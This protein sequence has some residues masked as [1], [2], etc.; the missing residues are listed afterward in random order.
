[1]SD[2][3]LEQVVQLALKLTISEQAKLLERV[4]ANLAREVQPP[5]HLLESLADRTF[6]VWS[7]QDEGGVVSAMNQALKEYQDQKRTP[8]AE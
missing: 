5:Q 1:M 6:E 8:Y 2:A 3:M 4:A 7:P